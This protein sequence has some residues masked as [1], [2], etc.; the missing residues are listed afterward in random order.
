MKTEKKDSKRWILLALLVLILLLL[1][2]FC[3][4]KESAG[5]SPE[6]GQPQPAVTQPTEI[7]SVGAEPTVVGQTAENVGPTNPEPTAPPT[8]EPVPAQMCTHRFFPTGVGTTFDYRAS[9][10]N[11]GASL[12]YPERGNEIG[13]FRQRIDEVTADHIIVLY[14][15]LAVD[16]VELSHRGS[17]RCDSFGMQVG[18]G[19]GGLFYLPYELAP[20]MSWQDENEYDPVQFQSADEMTTISVPAGIFEVLCVTKTYMYATPPLPGSAT[21]SFFTWLRAC[22]A[23]GVGEV[24]EEWHSTFPRDDSQW[25][26]VSYSIPTE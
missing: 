20:G 2:A 14:W 10:F 17:N 8:V 16:P 7:T 25:E 19:P 15:N 18:I 26:L 23:E 5:M 12:Q 11:R 21:G 6:Q 1:L 13:I 22:F 9:F 3:S 4:R 24:T